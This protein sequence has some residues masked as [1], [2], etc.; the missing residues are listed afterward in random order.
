MRDQFQAPRRPGQLV[1]CPSDPGMGVGVTMSIADGRIDVRFLRLQTDRAYTTRGESVL[2][3]YFIENGEQVD[4]RDGR[5]LKVASRCAEEIDGVAVYRLD[6]GTEIRESELVPQVRDIGAVAR[7]ATL[8]LV[9]PDAVRGRLEGIRL[10][11]HGRRPGFSAVLGARVLWL[12]HQIDVATRAVASDPVRMLLADEVGLGKTVEAALIYAGLRQERR[13]GR[14]LILAPSPLCIQWLGEIYR[15]THELIVLLDE[16]RIQDVRQ[17]FGEL[18]VFEA[19]QRIVAS[20]DAIAADELLARQAAEA[21]W[22]LVI[23]DEAHHLRWNARTGGNALYGLAEGLARSTRHLL[24][25][26]ATP[27]ALDP[28]EYHAL[29]RL[30]DPVRFDDPAAFGN[31]AERAGRIRAAARDLD[32]ALAEAVAIPSEVTAEVGSLLADDG[33]DGAAFASLC[34]LAPTDDAR[35]RVAEPVFDAL[36]Q[37]HGL[38]EYVVRNRRGPVGGLPNRRPEVFPLEPTPLQGVLIDVGE[39]IAVELAA[40]LASSRQRALALGGMLRALWAT[41]RALDDLVRPHSVA[42]ANELATHIDLVCG[43]AVDEDGLPTGDARLRWLVQ[44]IRGVPAGEKLLLFVESPVAV[45]ALRG[46][47]EPYVGAELAVFHRDLAPRDQDRQVAWFRA[48]DGPQVMLSTEAGGEGRNFQFCH[49]VVLYDMPWRPATIEQRIG[50]V[51]RVGQSHDVHVLVP[52]FKSGYEAAVL[53]IMQASIGVLDSTVGGIDHA[54]EYVADR[55]ATLIMEEAGPDRW[56]ELYQ[57][58]ERLVQQTRGRVAAGVDPILDHASFSPRS[59]EAILARVPSDLEARTEAFVQ[60]YAGRHKLR[61]HQKRDGLYAVE[62]APAAAGG[63]DT[64]DFVA[65]FSRTHALDHE[66]VEFLSFGHPLLAQALEWAFT[67]VNA[68]ATLA[69]CRGFPEDGAAF[70][71][72]FALDL[73]DDVPAVG[74][75]FSEHVF[76]VA[77]DEAGKRVPALEELLESDRRLE[78][79]DARP[80]RSNQKRW[81]RL[82]QTTYDAAEKMVAAQL[83]R[84]TD[85]ARAQLEFESARRRRDLERSQARELSLIE[86]GMRDD[87][88]LRQ[89]AAMR[90]LVQEQERLRTAIDHARGQVFAAVAVRL[91]RAK[92]VSA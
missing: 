87:A 43:A 22:D 89:A 10:A 86:A 64:A 11:H 45:R 73:P 1:W 24:L 38:A 69:L 47:L 70:I 14:V 59:A 48:K 35:R 26:T 12:P 7:L 2:A 88:Q 84:V 55:I 44:V 3:R 15:K 76:Q 9:H 34:A 27:M 41:P 83:Q 58:T 32:A 23:I 90:T 60:R 72:C 51:D 30:L 71:Y 18:N 91:L 50:R 57:D 65:T 33:E 78:R 49:R 21:R 4:H 5:V 39:G 62:G 74:A 68:G 6:D 46:A 20:V 66:E 75:Y 42:L 67:D 13:A 53:R 31:V 40:G 16:Q 52:Y 77:V 19:H 36:R 81:A 82:V 8:N 85:D 80:L 56:Q 79:M 63:S 61:L 54:L 17:D 25:L 29:L 37:R 92:Q 28:A